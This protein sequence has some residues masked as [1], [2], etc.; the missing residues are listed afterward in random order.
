MMGRGARRRAALAVVLAAMLTLVPVAGVMAGMPLGLPSDEAPGKPIDQPADLDPAL[1]AANGTVEVLLVFTN[2]PAEELADADDPVDTMRAHVAERFRPLDRF[3]TGRSGIVVEQRFWITP[4]ARVT[5]NTDRIPLERLVRLEGVDVIHPDDDL[6]GPQVVDRPTTNRSAL[7]PLQAGYTYGLRQLHVPDAWRQFGTRG[8]GVSIA[9]LDTGIDAEHPDLT[10]DKWRDFGAD[11]SSEPRDY[12]T[13]GT[14]VSGTAVGTQ[15]G[16][17]PQY[18]VA[19]AADLYVG[20]VMTECDPRCRGSVSTVLE[21]MEWAVEEGADVISMSIGER[22]YVRAFISATRNAEAAGTVVVASIGN[23]GDGTSISPAN[24]F[25]VLSV[26][27]TDNQEAVWYLSSGERIATD[28]RWGSAAP[29]HWPSSYLVPNVTAP[30]AH[31]YSSLPGGRYGHRTGTSMAAPHVAGVVALIQSATEGDLPPSLLKQAVV[32]SARSPV[33]AADGQDSRYGHGIVDAPAAIETAMVTG[34]VEGTVLDVDFDRPITGATVVIETEFGVIRRATT[35]DAGRFSVRNMPAYGTA[36]VRIAKAGYHPNATV[37]DVPIG[38]T[39]AVNR[40]LH[41][42]AT[43]AISVE[44]IVT[45][46]SVPRAPVAVET[47][48]GAALRSAIQTDG[49]GRAR[50]S[51]PGTGERYSFTVAAD[52][53]SAVTETVNI[54]NGARESLHVAASGDGAIVVEVVDAH[55]GDPIGEATVSATGPGGTYPGQKV[56]SGT[57]RI[58]DVPSTGIYDVAIGVPGYR[59]RTAPVSVLV[60]G[61]TSS[62]AMSL[63]GDAALSVTTV[64]ADGDPVSGAT[65]ELSRVSRRG[66]IV[67]GETDQGGRISVQVPGTGGRYRVTANREGYEDNSSITRSVGPGTAHEVTVVLS[68]I[69]RAPGFGIAIGVVALVLAVIALY[70]RR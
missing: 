40:S 65:I 58:G 15:R 14:H 35:D 3:A 41:G 23:D 9:V 19:P 28:R 17:G 36:T 21:G 47:A 64:D 44:D 61:E 10:V 49:D 7:E 38:G 67:A 39:L 13:H 63:T 32:R 11:P 54:G 25:D 5:V 46:T 69:H 12:G 56:G 53:Y 68:R 22:D 70:G 42:N 30:G 29:V 26:G 52:G 45:G 51:V 48:N 50:I 60:P 62:R 24:V 43:V 59:D 27:A 6:V 16:D 33:D 1:L 20:A 66:T 55:F 34:T 57:Y 37:I 31:V 8:E 4:A 18:G 2:P